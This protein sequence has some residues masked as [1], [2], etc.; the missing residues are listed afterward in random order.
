LGAA[1]INPLRHPC[2]QSENSCLK[3]ELTGFSGLFTIWDV[4]VAGS[5]PVTPTT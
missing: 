1:L 2:R 4:D 3:L 5:N